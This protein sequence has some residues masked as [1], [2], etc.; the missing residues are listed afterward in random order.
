MGR[1]YNGV[2]PINESNKD[3]DKY[4]GV[5]LK[6]KEKC[7]LFHRQSKAPYT[8]VFDDGRASRVVL[9]RTNHH[10]SEG[11]NLYVEVIDNTG[12]KDS[13]FDFLDADM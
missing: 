6:H 13:F 4:M 8:K 10:N 2:L 1:P 11:I 9:Y 12:E 7:R 3:K 5:Y